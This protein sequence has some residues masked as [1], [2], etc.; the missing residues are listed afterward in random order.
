MTFFVLTGCRCCVQPDPIISVLLLQPHAPLQR[1]QVISTSK[2]PACR[3]TVW[4]FI[5]N[6]AMGTCVVLRDGLW[7]VIAKVTSLFWVPL[8]RIQQLTLKA[9]RG[10][11][12]LLTN[13][14]PQSSLMTHWKRVMASVSADP[15]SSAC[16]LSV[17]CHI[18]HCSWR[19]RAHPRGSYKPGRHTDEQRPNIVRQRA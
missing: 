5:T 12:W 9:E 11:E 18:L 6:G 19:L 7:Q 10:K 16:I 15:L 14:C 2:Q 3:R 1:I 13:H 4:M 8:L 17:Y